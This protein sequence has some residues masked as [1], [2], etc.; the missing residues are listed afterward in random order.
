LERVIVLLVVEVARIS[1][2]A[3]MGVFAVFASHQD[4]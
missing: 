2:A 1:A 3:L 4:Q